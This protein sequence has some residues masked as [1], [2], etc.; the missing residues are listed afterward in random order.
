[1][2]FVGLVAEAAE[3]AAAAAA[4]FVF[5]FALPSFLGLGAELLLLLAASPIERGP[6]PDMGVLSE[7]L[8]VG[9]SWRMLWEECQRNDSVPEREK[10]AGQSE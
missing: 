10:K 9:E 6:A 2:D 4:F 5:F 8:D 3:D 7:P 1:M